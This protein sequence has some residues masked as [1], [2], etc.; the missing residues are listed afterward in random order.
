MLGQVGW[1]QDA[2]EAYSR[3]FVQALVPFPCVLGIVALGST[4]DPLLR[5]VWSDHDFAIVL[6][7]ADPEQFLSDVEWMPH[8]A[9]I[10]G[11]ARHGGIY[12]TVVYDD[13]HKVEYV[14]SNDTSAA[15]L[16][17]TRFA[18]LLDRGEIKGRIEEAHARTLARQKS[19]ADQAST[20]VNLAI[21]L[22]TA[23]HRLER[24]EAV[25]AM[26]FVSL[27]L[28]I[29]LHLLAHDG[30]CAEGVLADP[31]DPRRRIEFS[32]PAVARGLAAILASPPD[33]AVARLI[34]FA[35]DVVRP[36]APT[37]DWPA[38]DRIIATLGPRTRP[39]G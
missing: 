20:P 31:M 12:N 5:D 7:Q 22:L 19:T 2:Y 1:T 16:L 17:V 11:H 38:F 14:V 23:T 33:A 26:S 39:K 15:A 29:A 34:Q 37:R 4:A 10:V 21:V 24:G 8:A 32:Q 27:A 6:H 28:D 25:S 18:M 9:R 3:L 35:D 36:R 13:G 30:T